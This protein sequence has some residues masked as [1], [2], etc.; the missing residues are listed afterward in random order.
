VRLIV[1]THWHADH[2]KGMADLVRAC[3]KAQ[4]VCSGAIRSDEFKQIV[5]RFSSEEV[6]APRPPLSE[7][8]RCFEAIASRK[9]TTAYKPADFANAHQILD[10][11]IVNSRRI[12]VM[13]L[14]PSAQDRLNAL[15]AFASYFVPVDEPA[16]GLSP[17][18]QNHASVVIAVSLDNEHIL[19]G[20]DL[21][22]TGSQYTGWN[23]VVAST[24]RPQA[25]AT[26]FKVPHHGSSNAQSIDVW[27]KMLV[28]SA[29]AVVTPYA[30]SQL[31]R[32]EGVQWLT[33]RTTEA[34]LTSVPAGA[35]VRRRPE[36][37]RTIKE[38]T[39]NFSSSRLSE[40]AGIVRFRKRAGS[41]GPWQV[42]KFGAAVKL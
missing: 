40:E 3:S 41:P 30:S 29:S 23:A 25:M 4:F 9:G 17:T 42:E 2:V 28:P 18:S 6:G 31:P 11:F 27:K 20:A 38:T 35:R 12:E 33:A 19:L 10:K 13:A 15:E 5:A 26:L 22:C 39:V 21:E 7:V 16:L 24:I 32:P 37:E 36:V 1:A 14:S 8:K 34:Y